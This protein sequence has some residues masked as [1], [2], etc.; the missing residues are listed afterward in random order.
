[1]PRHLH[2][3]YHLNLPFMPIVQAM[4]QAALAFCALDLAQPNTL[5]G[6]LVQPS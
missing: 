3:S 4:L 1:M 2:G 5:N 6:L